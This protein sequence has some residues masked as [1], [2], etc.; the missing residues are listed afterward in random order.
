[1]IIPD[2][3][4]CFA[5]FASGAEGVLEFSGVDAHGSGDRLEV[6]GN[7]GTMTYDFGS[8]RDPS[9]PSGR[10]CVAKFGSSTPELE[11]EWHVEEDFSPP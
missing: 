9:R 6:Y 5:R 10:R 7:L 2:V 11:G 4:T 3:L 8:D 1:M